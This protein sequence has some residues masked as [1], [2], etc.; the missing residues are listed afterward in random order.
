MNQYYS[1]YFDKADEFLGDLDI[2]DQEKIAVCVKS[3]TEGDFKSIRT[4][5]LRGKIRELIVKEYRII[6]FIYLNSVYFV[7]AF[8]K[9]TNKT[10]R[11]EIDHAEKI[12][13][14]IINLEI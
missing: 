8:R 7:N 14:Q 5:L 11:S 12:Y 6:F 4:K 10:P 3:L 1:I 9:K 2:R 13:K